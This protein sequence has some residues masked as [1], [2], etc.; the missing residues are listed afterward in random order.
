MFEVMSQEAKMW[1]CCFK[2]YLQCKDDRNDTQ[3]I[4]CSQDAENQELPASIA[5]KPQNRRITGCALKDRP[6]QEFDKTAHRIPHCK[7]ITMSTEYRGILVAGGITNRQNPE[8]LDLVFVYTP[9]SDAW[10]RLPSMLYPR[11]NHTLV[12]LDRRVFALGGNISPKDT[13]S[14][15]PA[16]RGLSVTDTMF[17]RRGWS[18]HTQTNS[19]E[20]F[21]FEHNQ[22]TEVS[23]MILSREEHCS[24]VVG[25]QVYTLGG[26]DGVSQLCSVEKYS[27]VSNQWSLESPMARLHTGARAVTDGRYIFVI[28]GY[29]GISWLNTMECYDTLTNTWPRDQYPPMTTRRGYAGVELVQDDIVVFG[30]TNGYENLNSCEVYNLKQNRWRKEPMMDNN[31]ENRWKRQRSEDDDHVTN[32]VDRECPESKRTRTESIN[33]AF[34]YEDE[35]RTK[36]HA[37]Y[38]GILMRLFPEQK[39][40]V[41]E[42]ILKGCGGDL[43]QTIECVLPSHEEARGR[44]MLLPTLYQAQSSALRNGMT[45]AFLPYAQGPRPG[46]QLSPTEIH[47]LQPCATMKCPPCIYYPDRKFQAGVQP[48]RSRV[49]SLGSKAVKTCS[50]TVLQIQVR[51]LVAQQSSLAKRANVEMILS[52]LVS[53]RCKGFWS[54]FCKD[55]AEENVLFH[56]CKYTLEP[57]AG[58]G[59]KAQLIQ[60]IFCEPEAIFHQFPLFSK[61][62]TLRRLFAKKRDFETLTKI[63]RD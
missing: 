26:H 2:E 5:S 43:V 31:Y 60:G 6:V 46:F 63:L 49:T 37:R 39:K 1:G 33:L 32:G 8:P 19:V 47:P 25:N 62:D 11:Y 16:K 50:K 13:D 28:G 30:G 41:I 56:M 36:Q 53:L 23:S 51:S 20:Q 61:F 38:M 55:N 48:F 15:T 29:N 44:S 58:T 17:K 45:S 14:P 54:P 21:S 18:N 12:C 35:V 27:P 34:Q 7:S 52:P 9:A 4:Q 42:L 40:N 3:A 57:L 10:L 22:W 59:L 24:V